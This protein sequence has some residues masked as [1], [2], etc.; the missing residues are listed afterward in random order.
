MK[1]KKYKTSMF[2]ILTL[3]LSIILLFQSNVFTSQNENQ[4]EQ[5]S[6]EENQ[7]VVYSSSKS[8]FEPTL[9][10]LIER[11]QFITVGTIIEDKEFDIFSREYKVQIQSVLKGEAIS[12]EIV[13]YD[14]VGRYQLDSTYVLFLGY[15]DDEL[16]PNRI[17]TSIYKPAI[18]EITEDGLVGYQ[19]FIENHTDV[20]F[21]DY[22]NNSLGIDSIQM[23]AV[24]VQEQAESLQELDQFSDHIIRIVPRS[25]NHEHKYIKFANVELL[26]IFKGDGIDTT[27]PLALPPSI[28]LGKEYI[29]FLKENEATLSLATRN[30]SVISVDDP[31]WTDALEYLDTVYPIN[32]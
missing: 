17:H 23:Q 5:S 29:V 26:Q 16:F 11:A 9:D 4:I 27:Y 32:N 30:G 8:L 25:M 20:S 10:N 12:K 15:W 7:T 21:I 13:V 19:E 31:E 6:L 2:V 22:I 14:K 1:I 3:S 28:E 18:V 24:T